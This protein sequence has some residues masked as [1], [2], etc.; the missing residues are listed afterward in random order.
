M[1]IP[2]GMTK[3]QVKV[4]I[5][6]SERFGVGALFMPSQIRSTIAECAELERQGYMRKTSTAFSF[7]C[8][9]LVDKAQPIID[10]NN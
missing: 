2:D 5:Q 4:I 8:F 10:A 9:A 7:N 1:Y 3:R 6:A